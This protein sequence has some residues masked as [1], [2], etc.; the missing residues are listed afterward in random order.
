[1]EVRSIVEPRR[2]RAEVEREGRWWVIDVPEIGYTTQ[3]RTIS[4]IEYMA[5]DLIAGAEDIDPHSFDLDVVIGKP[6]DVA[7]RLADAAAL[8]RQGQETIARAAA[9]R[10]EAA[11]LLRE[12]H[13]LSVID[14]AAVL[15][16]SRAR[17]YQLLKE[18]TPTAV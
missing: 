4:E 8:E 15:G 7:Y 12:N 1:M 2:Y 9:A 18:Q 6:V 13:H 5:R 11:H 17:A 10:R 16:V 14:T 3:A